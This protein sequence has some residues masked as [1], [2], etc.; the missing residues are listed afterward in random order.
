MLQR[1]YLTRKRSQPV[2]SFVAR[3]PELNHYVLRHDGRLEVWRPTTGAIIA[4]INLDG[5]EL[6]FV[7]EA[8]KVYRVT[9][10]ETNRRHCPEDIGRV[11]IDQ[12]PGYADV[13]EL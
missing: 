2:Y 6:E 1:L 13:K 11:Y 4:S 12:K 9:D 5:T 8:S 7:R 10:N 3:I